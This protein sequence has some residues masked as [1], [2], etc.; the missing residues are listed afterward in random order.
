MEKTHWNNVQMILLLYHELGTFKT[1]R[2][3]KV[4]N[5]IYSC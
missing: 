4:F 5:F 3:E 2:E 1:R